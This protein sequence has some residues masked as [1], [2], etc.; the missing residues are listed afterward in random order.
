MPG[1]FSG[2]RSP[3][4][5]HGSNF[6]G[7]INS[8]KLLTPR[9]VVSIAP[10]RKNHVIMFSE[11]RHRDDVKAARPIDVSIAPLRTPAIPVFPGDH[12]PNQKLE[13]RVSIAPS[14]YYAPTGP[15][16]KRSL[17][18]RQVLTQFASFFNTQAVVT[19]TCIFSPLD[20]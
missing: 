2:T 16:T 1:D 4:Q 10:L 8:N 11:R 9:H 18:W 13:P 12:N 20:R 15:E 3:P 6:K 7:T 14:Q 19:L 17:P 5:M